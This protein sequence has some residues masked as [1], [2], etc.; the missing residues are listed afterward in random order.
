MKRTWAYCL[1]L[2]PFI[3]NAVNFNDFTKRAYDVSEQ[4]IESNGRM[5]AI[6]FEKASALAGDPLNIETSARKIKAD[7]SM[8]SGKE[9]GI[10]L[11]YAFKM[12][13][14]KAAQANEFELKKKETEHEIAAYKGLI[15]VALKRGWLLYQ[16]EH[17]RSVI[18]SEKRDFSYKAYQVGE[19]KFKAGRL[20]QMEFLRLESEYQST[21]Q[22][23]ASV[24]MEAEHAQHYLK[25]A[26]ISDNEVIIDDLKFEFIEADSI[27]NR[28]KN[29]PI[30]KSLDIRID[31]LNAQIAT[32][33]HSAVEAVSVGIGM[34][35]EPTQNSVDFRLTIPLAIS[36]KNENKIAALMS[37]RS[38]LLSLREVSRQKLE[39]SV[40]GLFDHL[41]ERKE[42]IKVLRENEKK[43]ETLF[44]MAHKGYEGGVI[45][46]FEYL[47]SKNAYYDARL[48]TLQVKQE[49]IEEMSAIEEKLGGIW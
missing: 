47:A 24:M 19:K 43:Y 25:E 49:Y 30:L 7:D 20:S 38:A 23:L 15:Q 28:I 8:D 34:T 46:Q 17:E 16:L 3:G 32:L 13:S 4:V 2:I 14:F 11:D 22:E 37:E 29:T 33:R 39:L 42:N 40:Q 18:L 6:G 9:Y 35:Q 10:M 45:G 27:D 1:I 5:N 12:P 31:T 26:V 41:K 21:V 48:R 36:S 44:A